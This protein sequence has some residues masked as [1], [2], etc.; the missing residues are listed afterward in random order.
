MNIVYKEDSKVPYAE[1]QY[2][3]CFELNDN[4]YM[5]ISFLIYDI[6]RHFVLHLTTGHAV[7]WYMLI[8]GITKVTRLDTTLT[9]Q[10]ER[11]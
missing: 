1:I 3:E 2:G 11:I 9:V 8:D 4:V 5:K 6:K 7:G 10:N